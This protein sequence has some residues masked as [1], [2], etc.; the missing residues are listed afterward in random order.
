MLLCYIDMKAESGILEQIKSRVR[1]GKYRVR[2][3]AVRHMVEEL[4]SK[5]LSAYKP[6]QPYAGILGRYACLS[7]PQLEL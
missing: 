5:L 4:Q 2:L 7:T 1:A 3:H 6:S